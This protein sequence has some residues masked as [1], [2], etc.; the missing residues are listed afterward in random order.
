MGRLP[1]NEFLSTFFTWLSFKLDLFFRSKELP[2]FWIPELNPTASASKLEKPVTPH[3]LSSIHSIMWF[4]FQ[5][6]KVLCPL[7]GKPLRM[8]DLMEVKFTR[9]PNDDDNINI[10]SAKVRLNMRREQSISS[11]TACFG[12]FRCATCVQLLTMPSRTLLDAHI[13]RNR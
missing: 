11:P 9:L 1:L 12:F 2:S 5:S 4:S 6:Q 10:I 3:V 13:W 8:K 7:S